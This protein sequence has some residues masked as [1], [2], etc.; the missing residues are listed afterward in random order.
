MGPIDSAIIVGTLILAFGGFLFWCCFS[1]QLC[2]E[3]YIK[4]LYPGGFILAPG[5][6]TPYRAPPFT[7]ECHETYLISRFTKQP[8]VPLDRTNCVTISK[9]YY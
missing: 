3:V 8:T 2:Y 4:T 9:T 7:I 6:K 1:T 5:S